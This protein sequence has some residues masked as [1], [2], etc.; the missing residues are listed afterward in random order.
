MSISSRSVWI[1]AVSLALLMGCAEERA[2]IN[3]VAAGAL[4]KSF[5]VGDLADRD[6]G[7]RDFRIR[8]NNGNMLI[9]SHSLDNQDELIGQGNLRAAV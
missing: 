1:V 2:P 7:C 8:D 3:R 9:V 4:A 5:F 6:Y